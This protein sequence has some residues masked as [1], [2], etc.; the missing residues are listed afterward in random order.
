MEARLGVDFSQV[1]VHTDSAARASAAQFG[2][3]AYT[4]GSHVVIGDGGADKHTLAHELTHVIQ[5][6]QGPLVGIDNGVG[7]SISDPLDRFERA[8]AENA[9]QVMSGTLPADRQQRHGAL[10]RADSPGPPVQRVKTEKERGTHDH[11]R[12]MSEPGTRPRQSLFAH[13]LTHVAQQHGHLPSGR[14]SVT[15]QRAIKIAS[16][17]SSRPVEAW[18][19]YKQFIKGTPYERELMSIGVSEDGIR[20]ILRGYANANRDF[21]TVQEMRTA[22]KNDVLQSML[23]N[24]YWSQKAR[25]VQAGGVVPGKA[26]DRRLDDIVNTVGPALL[27]QLKTAKGSGKLKLYRGMPRD[28][29]AQILDWYGAGQETGKTKKEATEEWIRRPGA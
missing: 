26:S 23:T 25:S 16:H 11:R 6:R 15:I 14:S 12:D 24:Q 18:A 2:A 8:A 22:L 1:R 19:V 17:L 5:Q 10:G 28:A 21:D 13:E 3:R 4:S 20:V 27:R 9:R 29:A 7:L